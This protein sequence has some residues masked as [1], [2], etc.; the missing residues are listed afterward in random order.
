MLNFVFS[1]SGFIFNFIISHFFWK[2]SFNWFLF[3]I[4]FLDLNLLKL[5]LVI[6]HVIQL[7]DIVWFSKAFPKEENENLASSLTP[8]WLGGSISSSVRNSYLSVFQDNNGQIFVA[9]LLIS[10]CGS[11]SLI[12]SSV[13]MINFFVLSKRFF[14]KRQ[15]LFVARVVS[16]TK[17]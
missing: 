4:F 11:Y 16:R 8:L 6:F 12:L 14:I 2:R 13:V 1:F 3:L 10:Y 9:S 15:G 17:K 5:Q 7:F